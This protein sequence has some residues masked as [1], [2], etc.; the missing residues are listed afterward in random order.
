M[1]NSRFAALVLLM[2]A[3]CGCKKNDPQPSA[4]YYMKYKVNGQQ[5]EHTSTAN[6][7]KVVYNTSPRQ[8]KFSANDGQVYLT[9]TI[10]DNSVTNS[11]YTGDNYVIGNFQTCSERASATYVAGGK[12]YESACGPQ[13]TLQLQYNAGKKEAHGTFSFNASDLATGSGVSITD[14]EF[15]IYWAPQ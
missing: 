11:S 9:I 1:V 15:S 4:V 2:A 7:V 10:K 12:T 14:G 5:V 13:G 6:S 3:F 8:D